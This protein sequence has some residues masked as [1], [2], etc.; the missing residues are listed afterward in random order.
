MGLNGDHAGAS[1]TARG[2]ASHGAS[3]R[4]SDLLVAAVTDAPYAPQCGNREIRKLSVFSASSI[5]LL[6]RE[7]L[8]GF[9][10]GAFLLL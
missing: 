6:S 4:E 1:V 9:D 7:D 10:P 5:R 3:N 8:L 2:S